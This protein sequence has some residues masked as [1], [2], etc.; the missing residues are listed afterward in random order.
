MP[1]H[2]FVAKSKVKGKTLPVFH[3]KGLYIP[4]EL[5]GDNV[6]VDDPI[7][8]ERVERIL[9]RYGSR[10]EEEELCIEKAKPVLQPPLPPATYL[11]GYIIFKHKETV[12]L[13]EALRELRD[14]L[15]IDPVDAMDYVEELLES[16][17]AVKAR[18]GKATQLKLTEPGF[19]EYEISFKETKH[20]GGEWHREA[21]L[22]ITD[23]LRSKG[24]YVK[25]DVEG[26][27]SEPNI[28]AIPPSEPDEWDHNGI[29]VYE[30]EA[31]PIKNTTMRKLEEIINRSNKYRSS[32]VYIAVPDIESRITVEDRLT[33][34]DT[35]GLDIAIATLDEVLG[36]TKPVEPKAK[37]SARKTSLRR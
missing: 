6:L 5:E 26:Y 35:H 28:V 3:L 29:V 7:I 31:D 1:L 11:L 19:L 9:H 12:G 2:W 30:V 4:V 18:R 17:L 21:I 34:V 8:C 24:W 15:H 23:Y 37:G 20:A 27:S 25:V 10:I 36:E 14:I 16:K 32:R 13:R 22:R 33:D